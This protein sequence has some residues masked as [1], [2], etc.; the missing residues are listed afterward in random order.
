MC[1]VSWWID[2]NG[3]DLFFNRDESRSRVAAQRPTRHKSAKGTPFLSPIDPQGGGSW[4]FVNAHGLTAC[5]LNHY[6][7][8]FS[9]TPVKTSRGKLLLSLADARSAADIDTILKGAVAADLYRPCFILSLTLEEEA[10]LW[11]WDGKSLTTDLR[12]T[13]PMLTTSS[14]DTENILASRAAAF[15]KLSSRDLD[16][17]RAFHRAD[18]MDADAS[19]V[20]MSRPDARSVSFTHVSVNSQLAC[21]DYAARLGEGPFA[22]PLDGLTLSISKE[23]E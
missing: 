13:R 9:D 18:G 17:L 2:E 11:C 10:H 15:K 1:T 21:V 20:R 7:A 5:I 14:F 22:Q 19:T 23:G 3:Y 8:D 12:L 16:D 4:I 6:A